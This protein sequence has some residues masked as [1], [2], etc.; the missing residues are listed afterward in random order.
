MTNGPYDHKVMTKSLMTN[1]PMTISLYTVKAHLALFEGEPKKVS[2]LFQFTIHIHIQNAQT[3]CEGSHSV[4]LYVIQIEK[5]FKKNFSW[6]IWICEI[7]WTV[8]L[9]MPYQYLDQDYQFLLCNIVTY[10]HC[11]DDCWKRLI[12]KPWSHQIYE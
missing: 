8:F 1:R 5:K 12:K 11:S 10:T 6:Y 9:C 3:N 2:L 4:R 7:T